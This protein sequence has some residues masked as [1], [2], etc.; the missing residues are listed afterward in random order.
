VLVD[1]VDRVP[2]GR[3]Y[4][5]RVTLG[6]DVWAAWV[7]ADRGVLLGMARPAEVYLAGL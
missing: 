5:A 6:G 7:D 3:L 1:A 2:Q 4:A